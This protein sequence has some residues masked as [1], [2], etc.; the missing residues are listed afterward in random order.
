VAINL[1]LRQA[2]GQP[3][4]AEEHDRNLQELVRRLAPVENPVFQGITKVPTPGVTPEPDEA[5][6]V[7]YLRQA[8]TGTQAEGSVTYALVGAANVFTQP[9]RAAAATQ[10]SELAT[11]G[12][13]NERGFEP[14]D[15][16]ASLTLRD[17]ANW[18]IADG[19]LLPTPAAL[20]TDANYA[21]RA[22]FER[23]FAAIG[24][25]WGG[26]A[27]TRQFRVPDYRG[28]TLL[29]IGSSP[30]LTN[31]TINTAGGAEATFLSLSQVPDHAHV[32]TNTSIVN[33]GVNTGGGVSLVTVVNGQSNVFTT[34]VSGGAGGQ[35]V[36]TMPPWHTC[37][38][39][40]KL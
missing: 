12:Q 18:R 34:G 39:L 37:Y 14:G 17:D 1:I 16:K 3:L 36:P 35:S 19:S 31:R 21:D 40:V 7:R 2:K 25:A 20:P 11:L 32:Y 38:Y 8:L 10:N 29:G 13:V 4:T 23:L 26:S 22:R 9:Q 15:I 27:A 24:F 6:N 5:V 33:I 30:G 28:R